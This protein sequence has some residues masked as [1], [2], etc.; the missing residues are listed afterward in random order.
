MNKQNRWMVALALAAAGIGSAS[1]LS[2]APLMAQSGKA[3]VTIWLDQNGD[4][5]CETKNFVDV[6]N[7]EGKLATIKASIR[8]NSWDATKIALAAG[9][10]PDIVTTPG[11]GFLGEVAKAGQL[12]PLDEYGW[13]KALA[14]WALSLGNFDGKLYGLPNEV[15]TLVLYYNKT[16]FA[17]RG[18]KAPRTM[19]ELV[20]LAATIKAAGLIPFAHANAEWKP[21]NEWFVGEFL[22]HG[23]G[24]QAVYEALTG[25]RRWD[26]PAFV[27]AIETL[28]KLQKDGTFM[29][30]LDRYYT[31]TFVQAVTALGDGKATMKIEG[32]WVVGDL[33]KS[34]GAKAKN[35]NDW[36][37]VPMPASDGKASFNIGIGSTASINKN[38]KNPA[39][40]AEVLNYMF[41]PKVQARML[42]E[43]G[44]VPGPI[45]LPKTGLGKVDKR[46]QAIL[47]QLD[48]AARANSY[49]YTTWTFFPPKTEQVLIKE[50]EKV[51]NGSM[52]AK[53][54]LGEIQK[55]FDLD[56]KAGSG[57][58]IPKR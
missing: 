3:E 13:T 55:Q 12:L 6:F 32:T 52:T 24:S 7:R 49:G 11:P 14:P 8:K 15:E 19:D 20:S 17:K 4:P 29:G 26:D 58:P 51:W 50:I 30:G 45:S 53:E 21:A 5:A 44:T 25:K 31:A 28:D 46:L 36:D 57:L 9:A 1:I 37:W 48:K 40:A 34:F 41:Q 38:T 33:V 42:N 39:A 10:G 23:A 35:T 2:L 56:T 18:W 47:A 43:C 16:L 54:Y 27:K 22:N